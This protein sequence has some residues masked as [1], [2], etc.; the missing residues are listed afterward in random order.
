VQGVVEQSLSVILS[1][2]KGGAA[3][4][5][6]AKNRRRLFSNK[7]L[8][9]CSDEYRTSAKYITAASNTS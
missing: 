6:N 2:L 9:T 4:A 7:E 8:Q 1:M 3:K 5:Q